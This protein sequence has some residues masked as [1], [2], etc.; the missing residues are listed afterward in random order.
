MFYLLLL[1]I[2]VATLV[3]IVVFFV[4]VCAAV[5][6]RRRG[7]DESVPRPRI[8]VLIPAHNEEAVLAATLASVAAQLLPGDRIG[9]VADNC[10]D[11]TAEIGRA[12][13][14]IVWERT[15]DLRR[16]KGFALEFGREQLQPDCGDVVVVIDADCR[17]EPGTLD[18]L[19]RTAAATGRP[20]QADY[21][22]TCPPDPSPRDMVSRLAVT[23]KNCVRQ[24][25]TAAWGGAA[26]LTGSGMAF[27]WSVFREARLDGGN[28][29]ED[30]Q[31]SFD[32][33]IA[34]HAPLYCAEARVVAPLPQQRA[35]SLSQRKRWE[36]GHLSTLLRRVPR[37]AWEG[38]RQRRPILLAAALDLAVPP[39]SLLTLGWL[40]AVGFA[41]A[42]AALGVGVGP[43]VVSLIGGAMLAGAIAT[44][45]VC[46]GDGTSP[47]R[48]FAAVPDYV[49]RKVPIYFSFLFSRQRTWVRTDRDSIVRP[50][51]AM[52]AS[53]HF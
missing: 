42:G 52:V 30:M 31:L 34:G 9:V 20:V 44:T 32:L 10:T 37:L 1:S 45:V 50:H 16:G 27:P 11:G 2:S 26:V 7:V 19:G 3:P 41:I 38:L 47:W 33:L 6:S 14:A 35:A 15:D 28:I 36:H 51:E 46:F 23:V 18:A 8:D 29:V 21:V 39:L 4:E 53:R 22:M 12:A 49:L 25:G 24:R 40:I 17:L 48:L 5:T 43:L 13:A